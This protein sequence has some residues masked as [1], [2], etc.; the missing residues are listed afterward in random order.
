MCVKVDPL[1]RIPLGSSWE[2]CGML[3][4]DGIAP[5]LECIRVSVIASFVI[6]ACCTLSPRGTVGFVFVIAFVVAVSVVAT[7]L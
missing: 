7:M 4:D 2:H 5:V 1:R 6:G 3:L